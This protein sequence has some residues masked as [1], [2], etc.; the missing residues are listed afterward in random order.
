[1]IDNL[2]AA[3]GMVATVETILVILV[4]G[5]FGILMGA[6]PGMTATPMTMF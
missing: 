6:L 1:M 4:A 3:V 5:F 2:W